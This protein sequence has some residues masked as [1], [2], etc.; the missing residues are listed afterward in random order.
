MIG[1]SMF[2]S[3]RGASV[4]QVHTK[5]VATDGRDAGRVTTD[6]QTD[7]YAGFPYYITETFF[8]LPTDDE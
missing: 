1:K 4:E 5:P 8:P 6:E 2:L 3:K 7:D